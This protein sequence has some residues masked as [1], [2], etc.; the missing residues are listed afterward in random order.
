MSMIICIMAQLSLVSRSRVMSCFFTNLATTQ[1]KNVEG[2]EFCRYIKW[3]CLIKSGRD[4]IERDFQKWLTLGWFIKEF[5]KQNASGAYTA[6]DIDQLISSDCRKLSILMGKISMSSC[7]II[8][9]KDCD[10]LMEKNMKKNSRSFSQVGSGHVGRRK[11]SHPIFW[12]IQ[13]LPSKSIPNT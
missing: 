4:F 11:W 8:E 7:W 10:P 6:E 3:D 2:L 12:G 13:G 9:M 5:W 1:H